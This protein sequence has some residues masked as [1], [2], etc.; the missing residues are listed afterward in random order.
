MGFNLKSGSNEE[1][2]ILVEG[3]N[4]FYQ[5]RRVLREVSL[6]VKE[7]SL[8]SIVGPSGCGKSTLLMALNRLLDEIPGAMVE[9]SIKIELEDRGI[10]DVMKLDAGHLPDLRRRVAL[11]FQH[12]NVLPVSIRKNIAFPL[13]LMKMDQKR[14]A[15]RV[16]DVLK[17]VYLWDEVKDRMDAPALEL[18]GGQKQRLCL[19]RVLA[20]NPEVLLLDEPTSFLDEALAE[21]IER[22]LLELKKSTTIVVVSHYMNQ[23]EKLADRVFRFG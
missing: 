3:L 18:S 20:M 11:V 22:M 14:I 6:E 17:K 2:K 4:V 23:V 7:R 12:P 5:G 8:T 21:K 13:G 19:A 15:A 9:G 16:E 1:R 10:V